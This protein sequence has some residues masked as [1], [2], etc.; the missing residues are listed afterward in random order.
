MGV[1]HLSTPGLSANLQ[2]INNAS[3]F[4]II[5]KTRV[6]F[7]G[8]LGTIKVLCLQIGFVHTTKNFL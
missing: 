1:P 4:F 7:V 8:N 5:Y 6:K 2:H 3:Q